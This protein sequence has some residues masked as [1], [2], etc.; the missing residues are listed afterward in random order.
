MYY[1][2]TFIETINSTTALFDNITVNA[3]T[4]SSSGNY[5]SGFIRYV[6]NITTSLTV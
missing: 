6:Y 4:G 2:G 3:S 1:V 5:Y